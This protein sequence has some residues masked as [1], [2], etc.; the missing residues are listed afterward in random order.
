MGLIG[1]TF[2]KVC[3]HTIPT[4]PYYTH[5]PLLIMTIYLGI[6]RPTRRLLKVYLRLGWLKL[7]AC[8][9]KLT[10]VAYAGA[11]VMNPYRKLE[12]LSRL[13]K[14]IPDPQAT[15]YYNDCK[16]RLK[17][18]W[19]KRYKDREVEDETLQPSLIDVVNYRDYTSLRMQYQNSLGSDDQ[20]Q[21]TGRRRRHRVG[22]Q[23]DDGGD[24]GVTIIVIF[25]S[26]VS[27]SFDFNVR[28][29]A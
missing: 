19:E 14:Q 11:V 28:I 12:F 4:H 17:A 25:N 1:S 10:S 22:Q 23:V 13:W 6:D 2:L 3:L 15:G 16:K 7:H 27:I 8:Y 26:R 24:L 29:H 18:L 9:E 20:L 5:E 21:N